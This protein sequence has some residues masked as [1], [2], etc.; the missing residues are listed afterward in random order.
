MAHKMDLFD[1]N[2]VR[3]L[4]ESISVLRKEV[5]ELKEQVRNN[6]AVVDCL[7]LTRQF[8]TE[9]GTFNIPDGVKHVFITGGAG[10]GA[11]GLAKVENEEATGGA[12]GGAGAGILFYPIKVNKSR[13]I[14]FTIGKGGIEP[15]QDGGDTIV[16]YEDIVL[17]L[18]GG[19]GCSDVHATTGGAG[20][21]CDVDARCSGYSGTSGSEG[22]IE[23]ESKAIGVAAG[24]DGGCSYFSKGGIGGLKHFARTENGK[25]IP[26]LKGMDSEGYSSGGGGNCP[27]VDKKDVGRGGDGFIYLTCL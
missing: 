13:T 11:G 21:T 2:T 26:V 16:K 27:G 18:G 10:G 20:G 19:K 8:F 23:K 17:N 3:I 7:T 12:G 5:S 22:I 4:I 1:N 6:S 15:S 9:S 14:T 25:Q 24:G